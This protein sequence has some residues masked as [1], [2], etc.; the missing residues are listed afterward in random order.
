[1][2]DHEYAMLSYLRLAVLSHEKRQLPGRDRFLLLAGT[3]ACRSGLPE[4]ADRCRDLVLRNNPRH[5]VR[6]YATFADALRNPDFQPFVKQLERFCPLEKAE[7]LL[8]ELDID[9]RLPETTTEAAGDRAEE[10][11]TT[12]QGTQGSTE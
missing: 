4:V 11:L 1:M 5:L 12:M 6:Q 9:V 3:Q 8:N 7:H 10:L 2:H